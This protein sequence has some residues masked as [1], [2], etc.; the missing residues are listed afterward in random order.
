M[1]HATV[2]PQTLGLWTCQTI[3][4][5]PDLL[6]ELTEKA[7]QLEGYYNPGLGACCHILYEIK[8]SSFIHVGG[9]CQQIFNMPAHE[10]QHLGLQFYEKLMHPDE[11]TFFMEYVNSNFKQL[12]E[13]THQHAAQPML[14]CELYLGKAQGKWL[15][16]QHCHV[17]YER[18]YPV[19]I[20][21]ALTDITH[22]KKD[23]FQHGF[24]LNKQDQRPQNI[25]SALV[26]GGGKVSNLT[27]RECEIVS[28]IAHGLPNAAIV[29]KLALSINT[30]KTHR[31]NIL[32]KTGVNKSYELIRYA[33]NYGLV[34]DITD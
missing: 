18:G 13:A 28:L 9:Q 21:M 4:P 16:H 3:E 26:K 22:L 5:P 24:M 1:Q 25:K 8:H 33:Y 17:Y 23:R 20:W 30:V 14:N 2:L 7:P 11:H 34:H 31:K 15:L 6:T 27:T 32:K 12:T 10:I 19:L 29:D